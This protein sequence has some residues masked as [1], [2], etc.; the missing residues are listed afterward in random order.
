MVTSLV[1]SLVS[2]LLQYLLSI[3]LQEI[4]A[5]LGLGVA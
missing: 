5:V 4:F 1:G 3:V 2:L